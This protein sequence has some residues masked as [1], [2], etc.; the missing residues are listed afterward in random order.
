MDNRAL[1]WLQTFKDKNA[2]L[3]RR[4][5]ALQPYTFEIQHQKGRE[6]AN[7]DALSHLPC[8]EGNYPWFALEKEGGMWQINATT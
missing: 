8:R 1:T 6:N 7:T 3:T 2:H 5:L 4:S